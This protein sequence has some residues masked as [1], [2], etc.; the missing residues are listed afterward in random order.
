M[1]FGYFC[2]LRQC[3]AVGVSVVFFLVACERWDLKGLVNKTRRWKVN[4][5]A[6]NV[7]N[8]VKVFD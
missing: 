1:Q 3:P 5:R 4:V 8:Q 6:K 2:A 7:L